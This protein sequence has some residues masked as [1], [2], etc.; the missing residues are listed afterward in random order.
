M[1]FLYTFVASYVSTFYEILTQKSPFYTEKYRIHSVVT[2]YLHQYIGFIPNY[3]WNSNTPYCNNVL[4]ADLSS[5]STLSLSVYV[6]FMI[7]LCSWLNSWLKCECCIGK[8]PRQ[9]TLLP[10]FIIN[11]QHRLLDCFYIK[12]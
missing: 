6:M 4:A 1:W 8:L 10:I 9:E 11:I 5:C 7:Q 2:T 3:F 12:L